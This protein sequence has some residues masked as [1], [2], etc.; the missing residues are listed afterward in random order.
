MRNEVIKN[1][2]RYPFDSFFVPFTGTLSLNWPLGD[3]GVFENVTGPV[4]VGSPRK[5][6]ES[7]GN[8][9]VMSREFEAHS[10]RLDNWSLGPA[11]AHEYPMLVASVRMED[12][13]RN[14]GK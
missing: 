2:Q 14:E 10:M 13:A 4:T 1:Q 5:M 8:E 12:K 9:L 6:S 11:F 3:R 7:A